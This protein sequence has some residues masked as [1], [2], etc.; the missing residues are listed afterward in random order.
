MPSRDLKK[1]LKKRQ[2]S[3]GEAA[4]LLV[5]FD[6]DQ[7]RSPLPRPIMEAAEQLR[8]AVNAGELYGW[9]AETDDDFHRL[10][11]QGEDSNE[12]WVCGWA[13]Y[14]N[15]ED[16]IDWVD[17]ECYPR[18]PFHREERRSEVL[19]QGRRT[20]TESTTVPSVQHEMSLVAPESQ[21]KKH[22]RPPVLEVKRRRKIVNEQM[23]KP[24]DFG[25]GAK[26]AALFSKLD[27]SRIPLPSRKGAS[28]R[29]GT[30][31]DVKGE[32]RKKVIL[33]LK[34]DL[35]RQS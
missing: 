7:A 16:L 24:S 3:E 23:K 29:S 22:R 5:G 31:V 30:Y 32:I 18:F 1:W 26:V 13:R 14:Y 27:D 19:V 25:D 8:R 15:T 20:A 4:C 35:Q 28:A 2:L 17:P 11:G 6:P 33:T 9:K 10:F 34:K 21:G 12:L